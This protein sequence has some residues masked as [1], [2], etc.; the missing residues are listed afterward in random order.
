[1]PQTKFLTSEALVER[2]QKELENFSD[3]YVPLLDRRL[4]AIRKAS[5]LLAT[6]RGSIKNNT[7]YRRAHT[8]LADIYNHEPDAIILCVLAGGLS[9]IGTI[10][11]LDYVD[12]IVAWKKGVAYPEGLETTNLAE[13]PKIQGSIR[14]KSSSTTQINTGKLS[15][16]SRL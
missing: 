8:I 14:G 4:E 7:L 10:K 6:D 13:L 2:M 5:G 1:M 9:E 12:R 3:G 15:A 16:G 11:A